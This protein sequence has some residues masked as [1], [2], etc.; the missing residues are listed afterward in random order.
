MTDA[1]LS[2]L[3]K[4]FS[5]DRWE[6][7][8]RSEGV[9]L[10][11]PRRTAH[12]KYPEIIYPMDYGFIRNTTSSDGAEVDVFVGSGVDRLVGLILTS[13]YRQG[14]REI[15]LLWRCCPSE[16]Y[17]AHGFINFDTS[18]LKGRL[19]MRFPMNTLWNMQPVKH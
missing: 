4:R 6:Q 10:D 3:Q 17:L 1:Y 15:K 8:I 7:L 19:V 18:K 14:D 5:W 9:T 12:P 11:R 16:V 2:T 13:D